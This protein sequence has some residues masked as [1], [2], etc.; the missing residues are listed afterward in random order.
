M[1][2]LSNSTFLVILPSGN[3]AV[4]SVQPQHLNDYPN[5]T[6]SQRAIMYGEQIAVESGGHWYKTGMKEPITDNKTISLLE[7]VPQA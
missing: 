5:S 1:S 4:Y 3:K 6:L 7:R 2:I